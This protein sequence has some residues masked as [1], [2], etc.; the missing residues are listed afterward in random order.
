M[1]HYT[2][3][4]THPNHAPLDGVHTFRVGTDMQGEG[5]PALYYVTADGFGCSKSYA[6]PEKAIRAMAADHACTV[7][8]IVKAP[9]LKRFA[10]TMS[11]CVMVFQEC[12]VEV[13]APNAEA[14]QEVASEMMHDGDVEWSDRGPGDNHGGTDFAVKEIGAEG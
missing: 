1:I 11:R 9:E 14:A 4:L 7:V 5:K 2:V 8:S 3:T 13:D 12:E 6:T 10:V